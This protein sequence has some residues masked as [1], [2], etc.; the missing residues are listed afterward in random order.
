METV[1]PRYF[2]FAHFFNW[3]ISYLPRGSFSDRCFSWFYTCLWY[4]ESNC[5]YLFSQGLV[6]ES[7]VNKRLG[8]TDVPIFL[9]FIVVVRLF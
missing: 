6:K 3:V 2:G 1:V 4:F 8:L 7:E 9:S 5:V